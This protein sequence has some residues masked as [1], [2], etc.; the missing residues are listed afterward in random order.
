[1]RRSDTDSSGAFHGSGSFAAL[2]LSAPRPSR[3]C[4]APRSTSRCRRSARPAA[5]RSA[6]TGSARLLVEALADRAALLRAARH[7][8]RLRPRPRRPVDG[9]DRRSAGLPPRARRGALRRH[10]ARAGACAQ[11]RRPARPRAD[12]GPLDGARRP[13]T[14][15][16]RR[17]A[18]AGAAALAA[19]LGAALQ[20]VGAAGRGHRQGERRA[21]RRRALKRVKATAAAGRA[22][23]GRARANVQG[24][25]RVPDARARPRWPAAGSSW[26]TTC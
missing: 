20:P 16:R 25:F 15:G 18:R 7:S 8:V 14:A 13:R 23:A 17:C 5:S 19:A 24:A 9:G 1:M 3:A 2:R 21:G 10:R 6:A 11:I 12:H 4:C 26:S 22:V